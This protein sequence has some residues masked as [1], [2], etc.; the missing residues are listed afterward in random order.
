MP[1]K[2]AKPAKAAKP[3]QREPSVRSAA[4]EE[5]APEP[6]TSPEEPAARKPSQPK[7]SGRE[8]PALPQPRRAHAPRAISRTAVADVPREPVHRIVKAVKPPRVARSAGE[9]PVIAL[10]DALRPTR[11]PAESP[12]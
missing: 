12:F 3:A 10:P 8:S 7:T 6:R 4:R 5:P 2:P 9:V 1:A 11:P